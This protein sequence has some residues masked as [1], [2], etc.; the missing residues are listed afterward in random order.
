[1]RFGKYLK[2][3]FTNRWNLL[4]LFGGLALAVVSGR[5]DVVA[6]VVLAAEVAYLGLLATHSKFQKYVDAH[7]ALSMR[8]ASSA[9]Q[10]KVIDHILRSIPHE[11]RTRFNNLRKRCLKLRRIATSIKRPGV[12][13]S[14]PLEEMQVQ[15]LDR[16]L[17]VYLR[18]LFTKYSLAE[19]LE[20]TDKEAI[21]ASIARIEK[22]LARISN[23]PN[24]T[25]N[26][27]ISRTLHDNLATSK[28]R[29]ANVQKAKGNYEFV[30]LEIDRLE[31]KINSLAEVAIN[32]QEPDYIS[33]QIDSVASSIM[34]TEQTIHELD[35]ATGLTESDLEVPALLQ[36]SKQFDS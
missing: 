27:K 6:P 3:A 20:A 17:W 32:R 34:E 22:R 26:E 9:S 16:L 13:E 25:L 12:T 7:E 10:E 23:K 29:L 8:L 15:G 35:F 14:S 30:D 5:F 4:A 11:A 18:L 2:T 19:F 28:A 24:S 31:S 36:P 1:V 21:P 33:S